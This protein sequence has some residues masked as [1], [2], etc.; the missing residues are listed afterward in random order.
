MKMGTGGAGLGF[1]AQRYELVILFE[2]ASRLA[3]FIDGGWEGGVA[4]S[5]TAG[6]NSVGAASGFLEGTAVFTLDQRGV[7]AAADISGTRFW[8]N[9]DLN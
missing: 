6:D 1:G 7:M 2:D 3:T 8:V 5:A 9:G 4:A